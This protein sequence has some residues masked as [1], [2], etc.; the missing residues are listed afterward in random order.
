MSDS[1]LPVGSLLNSCYRVEG[2]LG[3]GG[4]GITYR[5]I[6]TKL[7]HSVAIKEYFPT[8]AAARLQNLDIEPFESKQTEFDWDCHDFSTRRGRSPSS[9]TR[10]SFESMLRLSNMALHIW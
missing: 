1:Q 9:N 6:D 4:F 7:E 10:T 2:V 5:A 8:I 3:R